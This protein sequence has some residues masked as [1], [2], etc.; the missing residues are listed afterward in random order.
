MIMPCYYVETDGDQECTS[1]IMYSHPKN[2]PCKLAECHEYDAQCIATMLN[3]A[4]PEGEVF[5]GKGI[6]RIVDNEH[7]LI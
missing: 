6:D 3:H 1:F 2:G 7:L 5:I 4:D